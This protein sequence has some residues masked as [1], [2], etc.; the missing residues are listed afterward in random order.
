MEAAIF[1]P[2][3]IIALVSL[4]F[5][6]KVDSATASVMNSAIDEARLLAIE[7]YL[8]VGKAKALLFKSKLEKRIVFENPSLYDTEVSKFRYMYNKNGIN[9]LISFHIDYFMKVKPGF[10]NKDEIYIKECVLTRAFV[11]QENYLAEKGFK[12]LEE[13]E[14]SE[15]VW[16]F[17]RAGEKYHKKNCRYIANHA[18]KMGLTTGV[19]RAFKPCKLCKAKEIQKGES[20]YCFMRAGDVYHKGSCNAVD[21]YV[22][23]MEKKEAMKKGYGACAVCGGA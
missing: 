9:N 12:W 18:T 21:K 5:M 17:P 13:K 7:S 16:V 4:A 10:G 11:G 20:V 1:L 22:V 19:T 2:F 3:V 14:E 23:E 6:M 8:P 15:K